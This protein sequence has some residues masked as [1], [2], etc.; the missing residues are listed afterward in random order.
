MSPP[1]PASRILL[2]TAVFLASLCTLVIELVAG[3]IMAPYVGV[4]LYTWTSIIGVVLAGISIGAYLGGRLA[5]RFPDRSI[6]GWLYLASGLAALAIAPLVDRLGPTTA[7]DWLGTHASL[8]TSVLLLTAAGFFV[9]AL[10]LGTISPV[11][12]K[13]AIRELDDAGSVVGRLYALST[14]G[15]LLGTFATGFFL[16]SWLGTRRILLIVGLLLIA[17]APLFGGWLGRSRR[18]RAAMSALLLAL[19][20]LSLALRADRRR[21]GRDGHAALNA[22]LGSSYFTAESNYYTIRLARFTRADLGGEVEALYLD[23]LAHSFNDRRD[24]SFLLY[25]YLKV[26]ERA[27]RF[28]AATGDSVR[29]L[30][31]GGGGYTLPRLIEQRYPGARIDVVE[32]DPMVTRVARDFMGLPARTRIR[33]IDADARWFMI[34]E[35]RDTGRYDLIFADAFSDL[36]IPYHLTTR[37]FAAQLRGRLAPGGVVLANVIDS[38]REGAFMPS[39]L[40]TLESVFGK[41]HVALVGPRAAFEGAGQSTFIILASDHP[42]DIDGLLQ[43]GAGQPDDDLDMRAVSADG[44]ARYLQGRGTIILTDDHAPVDNLIA[45]LF[46]ERFAGARR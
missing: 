40:V 29:L 4:S 38:W 41:G 22:P 44:L 9:P 20:P 28:R 6:L 43:H 18:S 15:S 3:R 19:V 45:P 35:A 14:I 10:L 17:G 24:P 1:P 11:V 27:V 37:E 8:M 23:H 32:I 13:L 30:F 7:S 39:Y 12:V 25:D 26:F 34:R 5:D 21:A 31:V 42:I 2:S 46:A 16:I 36:S 33:T